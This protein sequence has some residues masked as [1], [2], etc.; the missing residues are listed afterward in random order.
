MAGKNY[1]AEIISKQTKA[2]EDLA[3]DTSKKAAKK[4]TKGGD[5]MDGAI[6]AAS[7]GANAAKAASSG[8]GDSG[9]GKPALTRPDSET[10][11]GT[12]Y[13]YETARATATSNYADHYNAETGENEALH[14]ETKGRTA[15]TG[16]YKKGHYVAKPAVEKAPG[17]KPT[18]KELVEEKDSAPEV[19]K[20]QGT[21]EDPNLVNSI[22]KNNIFID[23]AVHIEDIRQG[24]IGDCYFLASL[25]Q[26]IQHDPG[27]IPEI[28]KV[29]GS[30]VTTTL[31]H[32]E[33]GKW[34]Q[35][36][37]N[38]QI[39]LHKQNGG[40]KS[41]HWRLAYDPK[42]AKWSSSVDGMT[43]KI[44]R[45]DM[46]EAALWVQCMEQAY[47]VFSKNYGKYGFGDPGNVDLKTGI[48]GGQAQNCM[49]MFFGDKVKDD[50]VKVTNVK[51]AEEG[52]NSLTDNM[53]I[54]YTL[55]KYARAAK[56]DKQDMYLMAGISTKESVTNLTYYAKT[57]LK[58]IREVLK[59]NETEALKKA[60]KDVQ[61]IYAWAYHYYD[62][63]ASGG[64][65][66]EGETDEYQT[67]VRN[68]IDKRTINLKNNEEYQALQNPIFKTMEEAA[69][70][71]V[72]RVTGKKDENNNILIY[73]GH[74]YSVS[75]V[76]LV[77]KRGQ[78]LTN[79]AALLSS[80]ID[81]E[82]STVTLIN[83]HAKTKASLNESED[84]YNDGQ[85]E[86]S[87]SSFLNNVGYIRTATVKK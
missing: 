73:S 2:V 59:K 7:L 26:V 1:D 69:G 87:L 65:T 31:F 57:A 40:I 54:I 71:V 83:P 3:E 50:S 49:Y 11:N 33:D 42:T 76:K 24:N 10:I 66:R 38:V 78:D 18:L 12:E 43:L 39:G 36:D 20:M 30:T 35:Q 17:S 64:S 8:G 22:V 53:G 85:F 9:S 15:M 52:V 16:K 56:D 5:A 37:I 51:N 77:G 81:P 62:T 34:V 29:S 60:E 32:K 67:K 23:N 48:N 4:S 44:T 27:K 45:E 86:I 25:L 6:S 58:E 68:E 14:D 46:Y 80:Q 41:S 19:N 13:K 74:A 72:M 79:E 61:Q 75:D 63:P 55:Q 47:M 82:K 28:M 21:I 70:V 84:R